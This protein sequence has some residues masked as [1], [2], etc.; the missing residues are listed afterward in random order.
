[1]TASLRDA[2]IEI[3]TGSDPAASVIWLHGLGADG[4]D[5]VP[6]VPEL[7]LPRDLAVRFVFPHAPMRPVTINN[8]YVMRAW[9]DIAFSGQGFIQNSDDIADSV[10]AVHGFIERE[11]ER[12]ISASRIVMAGFSQ[13]G[14]IALQSALRFSKSLAGVIALSAP[15]AHLD[16]LLR[17]ASPANRRIPAFLA[18]GVY[19]PVVPF[20]QGEMVRA[21]LGTNG[22]PVE[23]HA[24]PLQHSVNLD[25]ILD[26]GQFLTKVLA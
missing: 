22:W 5:F 12:G 18:H 19:D 23:W 25:E 2:P 3:E 11:M 1:M 15:A 8:G 13:G 20:S 26:I 10:A 4:N 17:E 21:A 24:Y 6:V 7:Q 16:V 9:Y 14:A